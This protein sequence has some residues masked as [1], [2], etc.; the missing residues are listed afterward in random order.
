MRGNVSLA[1]TTRDHCMESPCGWLSALG[2]PIGSMT[3]LPSGEGLATLPNVTIA[4]E[5]RQDPDMSNVGPLG[6]DNRL[7]RTYFAQQTPIPSPLL[8]ESGHSRPIAV[9]DPAR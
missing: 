1:V 2:I 9:M 6:V 4:V 8:A 7:N 3:S 5:R